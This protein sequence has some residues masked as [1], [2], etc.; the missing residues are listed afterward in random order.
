MKIIRD[1]PY[2]NIEIKKRQKYKYKFLTIPTYQQY[3]NH[4]SK[5]NINLFSDNTVAR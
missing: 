1:Y 3:K 2:Q 5:T 4:N